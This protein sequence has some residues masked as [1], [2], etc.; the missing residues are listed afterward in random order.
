[1]A[2]SVKEVV[3]HL[4]KW[5]PPSYQEDYDNSGLLTGN[6]NQS[7]TGVLVTLDCTEKVVEEAIEARCNL[8]VAHHPII[9]K[10]IKKLTGKNYV[11]RTLIKAIKQDIAI[12]AIHTNL[13]NVAT[14]V[15]QIIASKLELVNCR[16]LQPKKETL[17]KLVTFVPPEQAGDVL[18]ALHLAGAGNI[19]HYKKCSFRVEGEGTFLPTG[20]AQPAIGQ[21]N[22]LETVKE[23]RI[24]VIF[25]QHLSTPIVD[26]LQKA[27]PYEEVAYYLSNLQNEN[28][29]VGAGLIGELEN[30][31]T[32]DQFLAHL[33][34]A[35]NATCVRHTQPVKSNL[36]KIALCGGAGHFLLPV[37]IAQ[38]AD[39]LV[40]ADFK[41]HEFFDADQ[42]I[43]IADIGHY[44]SE[45]F[46]KELIVGVLKEKFTTFAINFSKTTTNPISY[47]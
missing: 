17:A 5:A 11:E 36:K 35:M 45:Q 16:V 43:M 27:H 32:P 3:N 2:T 9:F 24:E 15:N 30:E 19:G 12:Y 18:D 7:I 20:Q 37:A 40:S 41:Y 44:E 42:K 8:I 6:L 28:Q 14:G 23:T 1:M 13:D 10:G 25:P 31:I 22:Q 29:E 4:E 26:A 38:Q 33:K 47:F 34:K 39:V 21:L 46:T